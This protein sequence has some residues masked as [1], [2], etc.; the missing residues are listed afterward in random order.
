MAQQNIP[1]DVINAR[2]LAAKST[3]SIGAGWTI[4]A[5]FFN[6]TASHAVTGG[7]KIGTTDGGVD[8]VAAQVVGSAA[9]GHVPHAAILKR[10]FSRTAAQTLWI[11]AVTGWNS[12]VLDVVIF[13]RKAF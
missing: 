13:C 6:E 12:A 1:V 5:I 2:G 4:D 8:V 11:D 9:L 10:V 3:I 7:M